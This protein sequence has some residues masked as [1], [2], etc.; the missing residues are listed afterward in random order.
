MPIRLQPREGSRSQLSVQFLETCKQIRARHVVKLAATADRLEE[1][2]ARDQTG[3][4]KRKLEKQLEETNSAILLHS[5]RPGGRGGWDHELTRYRKLPYVRFM[6]KSR[7]DRNG[8]QE[9]WLIG[10]T[11]ELTTYT[12][13][14]YHYTGRKKRPNPR[15]QKY[16]GT[17]MHGPYLICINIISLGTTNL[18]WHILRK[19]NPNNPNRHMH[20]GVSQGRDNPLD[21]S[22]RTCWG[23]FNGIVQAACEAV[24]IPTLFQ[25]LHQFAATLHLDSMM[26]SID[27]LV[28]DKGVRR[29]SNEDLTQ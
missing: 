13:T 6:C 25:V 4:Q 24:D 15:M 21:S 11:A 3:W 9:W 28:A 17:Y 2:L 29:I 26:T 20:A 18:K 14:G 16:D 19:D 27:A 10:E 22:Q 8:L 5:Q 7:M 1:K 23:A 12:A